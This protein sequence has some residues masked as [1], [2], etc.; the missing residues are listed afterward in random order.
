MSRKLQKSMIGVAI[1]G[2]AVASLFAVTSAFADSGNAASSSDSPPGD[3]FYHEFGQSYKYVKIGD[4]WVPQT[5]D[6]TDLWNAAVFDSSWQ[7]EFPSAPAG[8]DFIISDP[9]TGD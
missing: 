5:A 7:A 6:G 3:G 8:T 2:A 4:E 1:G 9:G